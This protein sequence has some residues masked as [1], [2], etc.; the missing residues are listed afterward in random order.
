MSTI[1]SAPPRFHVLWAIDIE[2]DDCRTAA[3]H[4]WQS[5]RR[6]SIANVFHVTDRA[7][8]TQPSIDLFLVT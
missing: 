7:T 1:P 8:G 5:I 4:A 6:H 3:Q 2:A